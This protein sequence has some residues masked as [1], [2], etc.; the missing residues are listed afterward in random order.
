MASFYEKTVG[1]F[2]DA[3][4][5]NGALT[6]TAPF[7]G[8]A[9]RG[10]GEGS[11]PIGWVLAHP[12]LLQRLYQY[13][14]D[15]SIAE[16]E[17]ENA[18]RSLATIEARAEDYIIN[19]GISDH[20]SLDPRPTALTGTA[21][22]FHHAMLLSRLA[23]LLDRDEEAAAY[24]DLA[25]RIREAF[26]DRFLEKGTGRLDKGTQA[27]QAFALFY[28]L[29]PPDRRQAAFD[30]LV[31]ET[32]ETKKRHLATGIFGTPMLL[33]V[34]T[35]FGRADLAF[36]LVKQRTF[37]GWG[38][39][40]EQGATTLWEHWKFSD[41]TYSH[42]HPM[43]G[44][45]SAWFFS[46]LAGIRPHPG[47][48]GFDRIIIQPRS[49]AGLAWVKAEHR[50]LRGTIAVHWRA[51]EEGFHLGLTLPANTVAEVH[52][53]AER[54]DDITEGGKAAGE[55]EGVKYLRSEAGAAVFEVAGGNYAFHSTL[56]RH[57]P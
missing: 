31:S 11:G 7:V 44:S 45:V 4:R 55:A 6:E 57:Q 3:A 29:V 30:L 21:F 22:F 2:G 32:V 36:H 17:Y 50:T 37:P 52:V 51:A 23:R 42:N 9:D 16:E 24:A 8:I 12:L 27:C 46:D 14:G 54:M 18:R 25:D 47:A 38:H 33:D 1:D 10:G 20:E 34:L 39:M 48:A 43:F 53:P 5:P 56:K 13:Y 15:R 40:L 26:T 49:S 28:D 41:D 35:R 19:H